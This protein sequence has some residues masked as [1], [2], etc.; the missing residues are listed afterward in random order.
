MFGG[1]G[2]EVFLKITKLTIWFFGH[3]IIGIEFHYGKTS[4]TL[5]TRKSLAS[6]IPDPWYIDVSW[7]HEENWN[8]ECSLDGPRDEV[9]TGFSVPKAEGIYELRVISAVRMLA[10][11]LLTYDYARFT[12]L[13][14]EIMVSSKAKNK[15]SDYR[16]EELCQIIYAPSTTIVGI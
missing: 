11:K 15:N 7:D 3:Y 9:I 4:T 6:L 1:E 13:D 5:G 12:N 16:Y 10:V 2:G 8:V 14:P